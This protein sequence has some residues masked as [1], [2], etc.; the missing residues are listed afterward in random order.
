M[1]FGKIIGRL[2]KIIKMKNTMANENYRPSVF[3]PSKI[4]KIEFT[5][6]HVT[7]MALKTGLF[8]HR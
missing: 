4:L 2:D 7:A 6:C 3:L 5:T 8:V 1:K